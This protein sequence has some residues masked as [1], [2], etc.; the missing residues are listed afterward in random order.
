MPTITTTVTSSADSGATTTMTTT[1]S[2]PEPAP[3]VVSTLADEPE[4]AELQPLGELV[5]TGFHFGEGPRFHNGKFYMADFCGY[6]P[7]T[8]QS[9]T[10]H[11][12][13]DHGWIWELDISKKPATKRRYAGFP[14]CP[15]SGL[16]WL[17]DGRM[18][19]VAMVPG[20]LRVETAAGSR[21]FVKHCDLSPGKFKFVYTTS[22]SCT[23]FLL[24]SLPAH[25]AH[26]PPRS[27]ISSRSP[28]CTRLCSANVC[29]IGHR[30]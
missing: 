22:A 4:A 25:A 7:D 9:D 21:I 13:G 29:R 20:E 15:P 27:T 17:P 8:H 30:S 6:A 23:P 18:L 5:A 1:E 2:T 28:L 16:G 10:A 14:D 26:T 24:P 19:A 3:A 12:L 11:P